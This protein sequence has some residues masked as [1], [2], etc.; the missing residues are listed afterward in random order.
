M[1]I[2]SGIY[3]ALRWVRR[4]P[5][6]IKRRYQ[7]SQF[8]KYAVYGEKLD[9]CAVSACRADT[10]GRITLGDHC[11]MF[12]TLESQGQG[13]ITIGDHTCMYQHSKIGA[14]Q[15]ITV[16]SCVVISN[17][18]QIYDNNNHPTDPGLR[19]QMC[20]NGF[21]GDPWKWKHAAAA[22]TRIEDDVWIGEYAAIMKGVTVGKGSIVAAHAV[23][24]KDVPPYTIVA[25]NPAK[26]VKEL[27]C[28]E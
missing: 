23:V 16:G 9:L 3:S 22:P 4:I 24:T 7:Y 27:S 18:V 6:G 15:E 1:G 26:V 19:H 13:R 10:P 14:V 2:K 25:G 17:H 21:D 8:Q 5:Y 28:N 20:L 11:R 12:G